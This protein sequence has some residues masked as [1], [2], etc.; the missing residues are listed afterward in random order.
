[1]AEDEECIADD[2]PG[3]CA[4]DLDEC[5]TLLQ[6]LQDAAVRDEDIGSISIVPVWEGK[7]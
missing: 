2:G 6:I 4:T 3:Q 1:M 7:S 5:S